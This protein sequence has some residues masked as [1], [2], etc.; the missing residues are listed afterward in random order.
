MALVLRKFYNLCHKNLK[1]TWLGKFLNILKNYLKEYIHIEDNFL[2]K[3]I[4]SKLQKYKTN[5]GIGLNLGVKI[6]IWNSF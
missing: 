2:H 4:S 5:L 6:N 3:K 1:E